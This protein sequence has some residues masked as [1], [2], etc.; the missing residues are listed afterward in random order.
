MTKK[1]YW[2]FSQYHIQV[3]GFWQEKF[4]PR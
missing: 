2:S 1:P 4:Q 3:I